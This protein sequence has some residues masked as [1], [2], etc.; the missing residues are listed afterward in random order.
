[1]AGVRKKKTT[2]NLEAEPQTLIRPITGGDTTAEIEHAGSVSLEAE[3]ET[4]EI[5]NM[6]IHFSAADS[7]KVTAD[8]SSHGATENLVVADIAGLNDL[9]VDP[10]LGALIR[11]AGGPDVTGVQLA[12]FST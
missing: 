12:T 6:V 9:T 4:V 3:G 7:N 11:D 2:G 5:T 8:L 1:L 10:A